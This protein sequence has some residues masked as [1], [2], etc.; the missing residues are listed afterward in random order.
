MMLC[1]LQA[2]KR[3]E[4]ILVGLNKTRDALSISEEKIKQLQLEAQRTNMDLVAKTSEFAA[5]AAVAAAVAQRHHHC[6]ATF[7]VPASVLRLA[8]SWIACNIH[9][10]VLIIFHALLTLLVLFCRRVQRAGEAAGRGAG[11]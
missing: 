1:C 8:F 11:L 2:E 7:I 4:T 3:R 5:A 9:G 6:A 10:I